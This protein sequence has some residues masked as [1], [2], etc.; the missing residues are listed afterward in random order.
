MNG[1]TNCSFHSICVCV[2]IKCNN[3][4][5]TIQWTGIATRN[6]EKFDRKN[7]YYDLA[8]SHKVPQNDIV[9]EGCFVTYATNMSS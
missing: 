3:L 8:R 5:K 4:V 7:I 9:D 6:Y 1:F 2:C